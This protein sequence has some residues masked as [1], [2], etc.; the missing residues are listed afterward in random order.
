MVIHVVNKGKTGE[1][2]VCTLLNA[3]LVHIKERNPLDARTLELLDGLVQRN[4]NQSAVGGGDINLLGLSIEV[5][6]CE[7]LEVEKWWKQASTSAARNQ[8]RPVLIYRQNRKAWTVVM[9]GMLPLDKGI[10]VK[11]RVTITLEAFIGWFHLYA[12]GQ[13]LAGNLTRV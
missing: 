7:T 1:R 10:E 5:K 3:Q 9:D 12:T 13:I 4:Q 2:E 6:R 8:D 11:A